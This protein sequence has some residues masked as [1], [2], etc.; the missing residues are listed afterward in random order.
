VSFAAITLC[1]ASHRA[2]VI[3]DYFVIG[4]VGKL[5]DTPSYCWEIRPQQAVLRQETGSFVYN[6]QTN[7]QTNK[8]NKFGL[9]FW[10]STMQDLTSEIYESIFGHLVG[11]LGRGISPSQG[12]YLHRIAQH[13]KTRTHIH[14]SSGI[15]T[16]DPSVREVEDRAAIGTGS[17]INGTSSG[18]TALVAPPS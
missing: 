6:K 14:T 11:L 4:S 2:F 18:H 1:V 17:Y 13:R 16:H 8:P 15:G 9:V 12:F 10:P 7:K 3:T 5:L